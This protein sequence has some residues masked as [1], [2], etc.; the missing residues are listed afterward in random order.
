[1]TRYIICTGSPWGPWSPSG[2]SI[3]CPAGPLSPFSPVSPW[4]INKQFQPWA[5]KSKSLR[6]VLR[7]LLAQHPRRCKQNDPLE[8]CPE[9]DLFS[10]TAET[11]PSWSFISVGIRQKVLSSVSP[12][13]PG[14]P[15][16]P[17]GPLYPGGPRAPGCPTLPVAPGGPGGP[18]GPGRPVIPGDKGF[19][20]L[21]ANCAIWSEKQKQNIS[22]YIKNCMSDIFTLCHLVR[23]L[24]LPY[25]VFCFL[26]HFETRR[27]FWKMILK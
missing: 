3:P 12:L 4:I 17:V 7:S 24:L 9:T 20:R 23:N 14:S 18:A 21:A 13:G 19:L 6:A 15:S 22:T 10:S 25:A 8:L 1:M 27:V 2:P 26:N 11:I 5:V 16:S